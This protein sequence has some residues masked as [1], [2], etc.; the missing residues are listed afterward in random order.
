[1]NF[2]VQCTAPSG[3]V[4]GTVTSSLG[5]GIN[6]ATV[7]VTPG[8]VD[9]TDGSGAYSVSGVPVGSGTVA[10]SN[11]PANCAA[12][13]DQPY[14]VAS[15]GANAVVNFVATCTAPPPNTLT[16]TWTVTGS[17]T[18]T[19]ELRLDITSGNVGDVAFDFNRNS[20]RL[21]YIA[22]SN[23]GTAN[24]PGPATTPALNNVFATDPAIAGAGIIQI[25]GFT[26][27]AAGAT[28][29]TGII[30]LR[31]NIGSGAAV[32]VQSLIAGL[33]INNNAGTDVTS[34]FGINIS[35]ASLPTVP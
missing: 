28:V 12:V 23:D 31:F 6:N 17:V 29:N 19:L 20:S 21:T 25:S 35:Q 3:S 8:G 15:A 11:L 10:V 16:G 14:N 26:T 22:Y 34:S 27:I 5:G 24:D 30:R 18:A 32:N 4:S 2:V 33:Q 13:A 7:T 1:V 9:Q